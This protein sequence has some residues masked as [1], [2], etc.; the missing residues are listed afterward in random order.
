MLAGCVMT[1]L[2]ELF[3][4]FVFADGGDRLR[5]TE[6]DTLS[7]SI[8][9]RFASA[10]EGV[11][12]SQNLVYAAAELLRSEAGVDKGA[13]IHLEKELPVAAGIGGGS[14]DAAAALRA[15]MRH[16]GPRP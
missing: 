3:S 2:H 9:G 10:L 16:W 1:G 12:P 8:S 7:L 5:V 14:A 13:Q 11:A 15:L 4:L 6:S